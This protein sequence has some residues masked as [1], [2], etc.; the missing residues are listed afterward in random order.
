MQVKTNVAGFLARHGF[1]IPSVQSMADAIIDDMDKGLVNE[2]DGSVLSAAQAM[3]VASKNIPHETP[4]NKCAI[5]I[6]AGGTNFRSCLV[7][8]DANGNAQISDLQKTTMPATDKEL[9]K[10][11]FYDAIAANIEHLKDKASRISFC[12]SYAMKIT[13]DG[14]GQVLSFSKE[15]KA[16]EVIG[17]LVGASLSD[18][19]VRRGWKRPEKITLLNDTMAA[20]LAGAAQGKS[21]KKY[22][23]Y[24][25]LI[26]G[27]GLNTAYIEYNPIAKISD[28]SSSEHIIVC[29]SGLFDKFPMS[30][31]DC[32]LDEKSSRPG[33][34]LLEKLCSGAYLGTVATYMLRE[35]CNDKIF[36][37]KF[38][39]ALS[40]INSVEPFDID[41]FLN[42]PFDTSTKLGAV[43]AKG[44][45]KDADAL[46]LLLDMLYERTS[47]IVTSLLSAIVLRSDKGI[48][49]TE[50]I[51]IVANGTMFWKGYRLYEKIIAKIK[52]ELTDRH[53]R[54]FEIVQIEND[55]T[56]GTAVSGC[57]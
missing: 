32:L 16:P 1:V 3:I 12:F 54:F 49:P 33:H 43:V 47:T 15:V 50:P 8:F 23:S 40:K 30:D 22:S 44:G 14:D 5:V 46:Y 28:E 31:F 4:K 26:L 24:I 2:P 25:G 19:L 39:D 41:L 9:S 18:A 38:S 55:I 6:D 36:S 29:E 45:R 51:C 17:T 35:A 52:T 48:L 42:T 20:L 34:G 53:G 56:L 37:D 27:T 11:E 7:S 10:D 13:S 57:I 21:G